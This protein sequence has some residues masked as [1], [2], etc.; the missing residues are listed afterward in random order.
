MSESEHRL[1]QQAQ[2]LCP[3]CDGENPEAAVFCCHCGCLLSKT[4]GERKQVTVLFADLSGF[5]AL[6]ESLDPEQV[7]DLVSD[8]LRLIGGCATREGG[9]V[10]QYEGD[11]VMAVFGAPQS[12]EDDPHRAVRAA[13]KMLEAVHVFF[14]DN[15]DQLP[16][17]LGIHAGAATGLVVVRRTTADSRRSFTLYGD[18]VNTAHRLCLAAGSGQVLICART[19]RRVRPCFRT[20][21]EVRVRAKGKAQPVAAYS[22]FSQRSEIRTRGIV[23]LRSRMVG[24]QKELSTLRRTWSSVRS[25]RGRAI[26]IVGDAGI[27]KSR[28]TS[29]FTKQ[30]VR[31]GTSV[32]RGAC[33]ALSSNQAFAPVA[34]LVRDI[35]G[36]A[37][38]NQPERIRAAVKKHTRGQLRVFADSVQWLLSNPGMSSDARMEKRQG[39]VIEQTLVKLLEARATEGPI[40]VVFDDLHWADELSVRVIDRLIRN[41][42]DMSVLVLCVARPEF[43]RPFDRRITE[44]RLKRLDSDDSSRLLTGLL[45]KSYPAELETLVLDRAEGNPLYVEE[46]VRALLDDGSLTRHG[47]GWAL[48]EPRDRPDI[49]LSLRSLI[50]SRIDG[51][52]AITKGL[53]QSAATVGRRFQLRL[54]K[55]VAEQPDRVDD[56]LSFL[57]EVELLVHGDEKDEYAFKHDLTW[58]VAYES[59]LKKHR[60]VLHRRVGDVIEKRFP[61]I[62]DGDPETMAN[63]F[64]IAGDLQRA[65]PYMVRSAEAAH[66]HIHNS[67]A[68][69][70]YDRA[71]GVADALEQSRTIRETHA[72]LFIGKSKVLVRM[73]RTDESVETIAEAIE[74]CRRNRLRVCRAEVLVERCS[75]CIAM[76]MYSVAIQS[77]KSARRLLKGTD[78]HGTIANA[79]RVEGVAQWLA[80]THVA[81]VRANKSALELFRRLRDEIGQAMVLNTM[82]LLAHS[83]G[84]FDQAIKHFSKSLTI[85]QRIGTPDSI[86]IIHN[87]LGRT[88]RELGDLPGLMRCSRHAAD[89]WSK[90]GHHTNTAIS[91]TN[92][93]LCYLERGEFDV[94]LSE[95]SV[96]FEI[97][98]R[99]ARLGE[100]AAGH[101]NLGILHAHRGEFEPALCHFRAARD[102]VKKTGER[103]DLAKS[104]G[105]IA[106]VYTELEDVGKARQALMKRQKIIDRFKAVD[107]ESELATAAAWMYIA[108]GRVEDARKVAAPNVEW[109]RTRKHTAIRAQ[110][111]HVEGI[112]LAAQ[113]DLPNAV[114]L[115]ERA[116]EQQTRHGFRLRRAQLLTSWGRALCLHGRLTDGVKKLQQAA[117]MYDRFGAP[118]RVCMIE[119]RIDHCRKRRDAGSRKRRPRDR[120]TVR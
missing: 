16:G 112:L 41:V 26:T 61:E 77:A 111:D 107:I 71:L 44:L 6:A 5:T 99:Y 52:D 49:P 31:Q 43:G 82:G 114:R 72:R 10:E 51:L 12:H 62:A 8:C 74:Y 36:V 116:A 95:L 120:R 84:D 67:V 9:A 118:K 105:G 32:Y 37:E 21:E 19:F 39:Q 11:N 110:G 7:A 104:W 69:Q 106:C 92:L 40:C 70:R 64:Q 34:R 50:A 90:L 102:I 76:D 1:K 68:L 13:L 108:L 78:E 24:R 38:F 27:G 101:T 14:R 109:A 15:A 60:K 28:L 3:V 23:G 103:P 80:G 117:R 56:D 55:A 73:A 75:L 65:L 94:A 45:G 2:S 86:A 46:F 96:A 83:G 20:G 54:L 47:R 59:V 113:G 66:H 42:G 91:H 89:I 30:L 17:P 33:D 81:A 57:T 93:G 35:L 79:Y 29:E 119:K 4:D 87:N 85:R 98:D 88:M 25:G 22:V 63:H 53:L 97:R 58:E 48:T 115:F 100:K 18:T